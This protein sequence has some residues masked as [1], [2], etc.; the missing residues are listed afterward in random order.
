LP[1]DYFR[2][3]PIGSP[4]PHA[5]A[6]V[7]ACKA[8]R[9]GAAPKP[10]GTIVIPRNYGDR[11]L[12][13]DFALR[14]FM[15]QLSLSR[16]EGGAEERKALKAAL[17]EWAQ[18]DAL[19]RKIQVEGNGDKGPADYETST[20]IMTLLDGFAETA[21]LMT[22][23]ERAAVGV[24]LNRF[25]ATA[26]GSRVMHRQDNKTVLWAYMT[27]FWGLTVGDAEAVR[28]GIDVYNLGIHDMR[29]DGSHT[30][31]AERGGMGLHYN[32]F[33]TGNLVMIAALV[34]E[35]LGLDLFSYE[36]DGRSVHTAVDFV[37]A[38]I[39]DPSLNSRYA[40]ACAKSGDRF[41]PVS[42][43]YLAYTKT[44]GGALHA[45]YMLVYAKYFPGRETSRW[46]SE[47][48]AYAFKD[49]A[50][51]LWN[52]GGAPACLFNVRPPA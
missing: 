36:V 27:L 47:R 2:T 44:D 11:N 18:A 3:A 17:V 37:A 30:L 8:Y 9:V 25:I 22:A 19:H 16:G 24:W 42:R 34:K 4:L 43:P 31:D 41:G 46:I 14:W 7:P 23:D 40:I 51:N 26:A 1:A 21:D 38:T 39:K 49:P 28:H 15:S 10:L 13:V 33:K 52:A 50:A 45:A 32:N 5:E 20:F 6:D 48:F 29:P 12:D 35:R